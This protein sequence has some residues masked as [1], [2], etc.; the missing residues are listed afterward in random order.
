MTNFS[1]LWI[2]LASTGNAS[3]TAQRP[4]FYAFEWIGISSFVNPC[5]NYLCNLRSTKHP[6]NSSTGH[7]TRLISAKGNYLYLLDENP[8]RWL[9]P[10]DIRVSHRNVF[11]PPSCDGRAFQV[12]S[13][14]LRQ[15][16]KQSVSNSNR[17]HPFYF[18]RCCLIR[19]GVRKDLS[20]RTYWQSRVDIPGL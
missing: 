8:G 4:R 3:L 17:V 7:N 14:R 6:S 2:S 11:Y 12:L 9:W 10:S 1:T 16:P 18:Y 20:I 15:E 19:L 5:W 13:P